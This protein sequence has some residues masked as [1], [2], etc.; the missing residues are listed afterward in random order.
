MDNRIKELL[1]KELLT[2]EEAKEVLDNDNITNWENNG[3]SGRYN[4]YT[5]FTVIAIDGEEYQI[6][7][8]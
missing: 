5:W 1:K 4:G 7:N 6:Y 3:N 8:K 2:C